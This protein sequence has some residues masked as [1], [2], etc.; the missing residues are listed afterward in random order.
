[1]YGAAKASLA[2]LTRSL[3]KDLAPNIRVNA[4]APG[5]IAWPD[6]GLADDV[7]KTILGQVPLARTG[8]PADVAAA[9]LFFVKDAG[10]VTGQ[11]LAVD[12]GR[13]IGW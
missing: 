1:M 7:K 12:G 10:Y 11:I 8:D 6:S 4:I 2:M 5:A 3:A 13:S 9:V